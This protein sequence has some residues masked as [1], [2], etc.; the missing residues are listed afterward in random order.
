ML[1]WFVA[2]FFLA[3]IN[4]FGGFQL[5]GVEFLLISGIIGVCISIEVFGG[6]K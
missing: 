3:L 4:F 1:S 6:R 2:I 5:S